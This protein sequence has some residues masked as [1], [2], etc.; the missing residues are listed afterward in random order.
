MSAFEARVFSSSMA[1]ARSNVLWSRTRPLSSRNLVYENPG[2]D[3][4]VVAKHGSRHRHQYQSYRPVSPPAHLHPG[5]GHP[6]SRLYLDYAGPFL[7]HMFL[8]LVDAHSKWVELFLM[9]SATSS[10]SCVLCLLSLGFP[11][12]W[13]P[14]MAPVSPVRNSQHF[15][16]RMVFCTS[17]QHHTTLPQMGWLVQSFKQGMRKFTQGTLMDRISRFLFHYRNTPQLV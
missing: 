14:T 1:P 10:R 2:T 8:L 12:L 9:S 16:G 11:T 17:L 13:P 4:C 7:G 5:L 15:S 3:I 6:W